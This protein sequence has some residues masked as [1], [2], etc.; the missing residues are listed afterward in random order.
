MERRFIRKTINSFKKSPQ[1][2]I[3]P[4]QWKNNEEREAII[5]KILGL[6]KFPL[7][8]LIDIL[9]HAH[10]ITHRRN[11]SELIKVL[12]EIYTRSKEPGISEPLVALLRSTTDLETRD[13]IIRILSRT[14]DE[15]HIPLIVPFML[16]PKR[17]FRIA[18]MKLLSP[19]SEAA[20]AK[21]LSAELMK[22]EWSERSDA[23]NYL[24]QI[25]PKSTAQPCRRALEIGTEEEKS[26]ALKI[27]ISLKTPEAARAMEY[28]LD[29]SATQ[30]RLQVA[31]AMIEIG[32]PTAV[33][34]LIKLCNDSKPKVVT[35]ALRGLRRLKSPAGIN[36]VVTCI[37]N[38]NVSIRIEAIKALGEIGTADEVI[39]LTSALKER[40]I[41]IR[42][43]S[44]EALVALSQSSETDIPKFVSLLMSNEDVNVRRAAAQ[45]LGQVDA[46]GL[47]EKLFEYLRDDDWWVRE[48]IA[49]TLSKI[50]DDRILPAAI[51]LLANPDSSLRRY[52]ID[53]M[54]GLKDQRGL[55]PMIKMLKDPD[56]WVR[57]R[58]VIA[59]GSMGSENIVPI[60]A[61][62]LNI[63]ELAYVTA[64]S[65]GEIRHPSAIPYLLKS[66]TSDDPDTRMMVMSA[67]EKLQ[68][69]EAIVEIE[70]LLTDPNR[71]VRYH[72]K[73]VLTR[74]KVDINQMDEIS[75]RWWEQHE[76]SLLDTL[77]MEVRYQKGTD[78]FLISNSP[79][80][81]RINGEMIPLSRENLSEEHILAMASQTLSPDQEQ[82]FLKK[83]DLDFSYE[84]ADEGRFR[85]NM[86]RHAQ[87]VNL[88]FRLLPD[89]IPELTA[90]GLPPILSDLAQLNHGLI[91]V[92]GPSACGKTTTVAAIINEMNRTRSDHIITIEDPIEFIHVRKN[93]L[94]TQRE[95]G[96]HTGS[97]ARALRAALREDPD[98]ILVGE[99]RDLETISMA[100]SAAETGHLVL[101]TMHSISAAKTLD[102]IIDVYPVT[103][104]GQ[105]RTML[106][107]S[108]TAI[109]TQQLI[110][111]KDQKGHAV[112]MEILI[113]SSAISGLIRE[114]KLFQIPSL[115]MA[116]QQHGMLAMDQC[117]LKLLKEDI[118]SVED[119]YLRAVDRNQ[120][121]GY[122]KLERE[123]Q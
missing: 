63:K 36:A 59:L 7:Q 70:K 9:A 13:A 100:L 21:A 42:Q 11:K 113:N 60:L 4:G 1:M 12:E 39:Y 77:L 107:E 116:G 69:E 33:R 109:L 66:L 98:V 40:D 78:L 73:E 26:Q 64:Q 75:A 65:L 94:V 111:R 86:F 93:C 49:E 15:S 115:M 88:V 48:T 89:E 34:N 32:G 91:L 72:A 24:Y 52:A 54:V 97:F 58:A 99:L 44:L 53:I 106:S 90:L 84:I 81:A 8:E 119:A 20:V 110:P 37:T 23:I 120:F 61:N 28:V 96:R 123:I 118:I 55:V 30:I 101:A 62:L 85:G 80:M 56:W 87:G 57:E 121:E 5:T 83:N 114:N 82:S 92:T 16:H 51:D 76:F 67:L 103:K 50:R 22:G 79:P 104:Q 27:L 41:R 68:A 74:L 29:D 71:E 46:P 3:E 2:L 35:T 6:K 108:L 10:S 19:F 43:T 17:Y 105:I 14:A 25:D 38:D 102:R 18:A 45:I 31:E 122:I 95:V 47:F 112:A 117:L